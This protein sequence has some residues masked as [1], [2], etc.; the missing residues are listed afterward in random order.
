V[1]KEEDKYGSNSGN[2]SWDGMIGLVMSGKADIGAS[3]F[4]M[5][6]EKSEVVA[7]TDTLGSGR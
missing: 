4:I 3:V 7:Y 2:G 1:I 6:K 5:T